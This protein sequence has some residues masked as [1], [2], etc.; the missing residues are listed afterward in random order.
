MQPVFNYNNQTDYTR[1]NNP[2][3][4]E[5]MDTAKKIINPNKKEEVYKEIQNIIIEDY[6][7]IPVFHPKVALVT[8]K[9]IVGARISPLGIINYE[10]ILIES[11]KNA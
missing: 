3:V 4:I 6:P 5:L 1:Y 2:K 10:N 9:G 7:W 11:N 8:R